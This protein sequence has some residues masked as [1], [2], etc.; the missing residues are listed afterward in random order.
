MLFSFTNLGL[1]EF[2]VGYLAF[3][4][5]FLSNRR[6]WVVLD[7]KSSQEYLLYLIASELDSDLRD[8]VDLGVKWLIDFNAGETQLVLFDQSGNTGAIDIKMDGSSFRKLGLT[9]S[10]KWDWGSYIISV[11]ETA[12]YEVSFS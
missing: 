8:T 7:G 11:V 12:Y 3:I 10:A 1:V 2:Q 6:L 9:F 4:S 5:S